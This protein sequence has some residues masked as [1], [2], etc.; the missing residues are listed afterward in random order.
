MMAAMRPAVLAVLTG[1]LASA[2]AQSSLAQASLEEHFRGKTISVIIPTTPGGDRM[3]NATPFM[4]FFGRHIPGHPNVIPQFMPG[5]GGAVGMNYLQSVASRD[6]L[7]IATPLA[8][9]T[10]AQV[11]GDK[12]VKYDASKMNWIG[13]TSDSTQGLYVSRNA[14]AQTFADLRTNR[15]V[16]GSSGLASASTI[17]PYVMNHVFGTQMHVV[18]GYS[19]SAAFNLAVQ[20]G[21]TDGALTTWGTVSN[22]HGAELREGKIRVLFQVALARNPDL[23]AIAAALELA[24][25]DD[26]RAMIELMSASSEMGQSFVA[27]PSVPAP[28][29]EALRRAFDATMKDPDYI[30]LSQR[31]GNA[32]N[33]LGGE[34]LTT[35]VNRTLATPQRVVDRYQAAVSAI[36]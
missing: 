13:R 20:R 33:P 34:A 36:R 30:A 14:K 19:G 23:P 16:I 35:I 28:V 9:V 6:G 22:N 21:E 27:P 15:V 25:N 8:P 5:A 31:A 3:A 32:I 17:I 1:L 29:V 24:T 12:A 26:D 4:R 7:T 10:V 11:T 2:Y 18:L